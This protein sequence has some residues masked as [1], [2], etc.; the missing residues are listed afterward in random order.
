MKSKLIV[1]II[2]ITFSIISTIPPNSILEVAND[3]LNIRDS[4]CTNG[5]IITTLAK[6]ARVTY[7]NKQQNGCNYLWFQI[8]GNF[9]VGYGAS[10]FLRVVQTVN[11]PGEKVAQWAIT[12]VGKGY[13]QRYI[14]IKKDN[15]Q[16]NVVD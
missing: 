9:G 15:A 5:R 11:N 4:P 3:G 13:T 8:K 1:L 16:H 14:I 2:F 12:Q 6:G 7:N 10:N